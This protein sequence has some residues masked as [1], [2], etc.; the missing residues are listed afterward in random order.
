MTAS[1]SCCVAEFDEVL[2]GHFGVDAAVG[3]ENLEF[4]ALTQADDG[5]ICTNAYV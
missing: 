4:A 2:R 3:A 1:T 5:F